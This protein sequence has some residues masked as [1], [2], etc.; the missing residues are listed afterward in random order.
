[1]AIKG[2][3]ADEPRIQCGTLPRRRNGTSVPSPLNSFIRST[4]TNRLAR[5]SEQQWLV[6]LRAMRSPGMLG[7][8]TIVFELHVDDVVAAFKRVLDASAQVKLHVSR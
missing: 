3:R 8:T 1:M 2:P 4:S 6:L 7:R 5:R